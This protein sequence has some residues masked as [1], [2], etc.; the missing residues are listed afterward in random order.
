MRAVP[1]G[2]VELVE[3]RIKPPGSSTVAIHDDEPVVAGPEL[4]E[5]RAQLGDDAVGIQ[6]QV[7]GQAVD[8]DVPAPA[9]GDLF[10]PGSKGST[11]DHGG[12]ARPPRPLRPATPRG[13]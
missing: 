12:S 6:V 2:G 3:H 8:V 11:P 13:G 4:A 5:L 1:V 7:C 9:V 10:Y